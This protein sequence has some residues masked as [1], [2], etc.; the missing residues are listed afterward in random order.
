DVGTVFGAVADKIELR[1]D[2]CKSDT[3]EIYGCY[4]DFEEHETRDMTVRDIFT[5]SSN[6]GI[7]RIAQKMPEGLLGSYIER[8]GLTTATGIDYTGESNGLLNLAPGRPTCP[9]SA[10]TG[11]SIASFPPQAA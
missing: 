5:V 11:P 3:D 2:A 7:I 6:V 1:P 9:P 10:A 4:T 8:F